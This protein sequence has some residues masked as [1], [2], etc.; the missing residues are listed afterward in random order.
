L[1]IFDMWVGRG[2]GGVGFALPKYQLENWVPLPPFTYLFYY[3]HLE[4]KGGIAHHMVIGQ[5]PPHANTCKDVWK[6]TEQ[7]S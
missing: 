2:G 7:D 4:N 5:H 3:L 6:G 1:K